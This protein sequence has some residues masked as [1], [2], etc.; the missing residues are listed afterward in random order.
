MLLGEGRH[1][2]VIRKK[3][4]LAQIF[5]ILLL[6]FVLNFCASYLHYY[7]CK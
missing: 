7:P 5:G 4:R 1:L 2:Y 6:R 3:H